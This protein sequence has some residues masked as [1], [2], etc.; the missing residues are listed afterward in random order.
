MYKKLVQ[1]CISSFLGS[2][3]PAWLLFIILFGLL[4]SYGRMHVAYSAQFC[5]I[6][7]PF[8]SISQHMLLRLATIQHHAWNVEEHPDGLSI[9][10]STI[11]INLSCLGR[12]QMEQENIKC[13]RKDITCMAEVFFNSPGSDKCRWKLS[14]WEVYN[15]TFPCSI[16]SALKKLKI[17]ADTCTSLQWL[18]LLS[19]HP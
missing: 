4:C 1:L 16:N 5:R 17:L 7:W 8:P 11:V 6:S 2:Y 3:I 14:S 10:A 9:A 19:I 18:L 12:F 15:S 13:M